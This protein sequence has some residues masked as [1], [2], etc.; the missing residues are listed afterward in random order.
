MN[1]ALLTTIAE[2]LFKLAPYAFNTVEEAKPLA[3]DFIVH[4]K[5]DKTSPEDAAALHAKIEELTADILKD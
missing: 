3:K 5:G 1:V 4:I 2:A